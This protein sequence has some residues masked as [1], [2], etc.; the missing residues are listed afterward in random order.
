MWGCMKQ[1]EVGTVPNQYGTWPFG[2]GGWCPGL[3]VAPFVV[4]VT[5]ALVDGENELTY[6]GLLDGEPF[7]PVPA[8]NGGFKGGIHMSSWLIYWR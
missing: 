4:D 5:E 8:S 1:I 2:R 6:L 7:V 3:D